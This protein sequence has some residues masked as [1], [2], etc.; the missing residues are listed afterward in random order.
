MAEKSYLDK[1]RQ[2]MA[3]TDTGGGRSGFWEIPQGDT[4]IRILPPVGEM[5]FF[6]QEVG[7]HRLPDGKF[8][9]CPSFTTAGE[10]DCPICDLVNQLYKSGNSGDKDLAG[11]LRRSRKYWVNIIARE[12]G[13]KGGD[14]GTGPVIFTAGVT[15]FRALQTLINSPDYGDITHPDE[16]FDLI[17]NRKGEK[18][19]TQYSVMPRPRPCPI[20]TNKEQAEDFLAAAADLTPVELSMDPGE[21]A[22][23]GGDA[24]V[25]LL[26][27][28]R[29]A[30]ETG[31]KPGANISSL[32]KP[33]PP[34]EDPFPAPAQ[35]EVPAQPAD[36]VESAFRSRRT[37]RQ[38]A[39]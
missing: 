39:A 12:K 13:D 25:A 28:D 34:D 15:V 24:M 2:K 17:I 18:L 32:V 6:F 4:T 22:E 29:L 19:E 16:G 26:P 20:H 31:L 8:V 10:L 1:L 38:R 23:L 27:Y 36:D 3:N 11:Q 21:D 7:Q 35:K 37:R 14:T 33:E 9:Y 5:E 30:S